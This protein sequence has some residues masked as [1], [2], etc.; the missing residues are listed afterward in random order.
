M[1]LLMK[2]LFG[3]WTN[4]RYIMHKIKAIYSLSFLY[5][6]LF[7]AY[8]ILCK[9]PINISILY[10]IIKHSSRSLPLIAILFYLVKLAFNEK[11]DIFLSNVLE[12]ILPL[13]FI[14]YFLPYF[15]EYIIDPSKFTKGI[16][17][18]FPTENSG[19]VYQAP[20]ISGTRIGGMMSSQE[21]FKGIKLNILTDPNVNK[22]LKNIGSGAS[23]IIQVRIT[24]GKPQIDTLNPHLYLKKAKT[25]NYLRLDNYIVTKIIPTWLFDLKISGEM[26][27]TI[28]W[29]TLAIY[30]NI[31]NIQSHSLVNKISVYDLFLNDEGWNIF[32]LIRK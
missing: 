1:V 11:L 14:V 7:I 9:S 4:R 17:N 25:D 15:N 3:K 8:I 16:S 29:N 18:G 24:N 26:E 27:I 31:E 22:N 13:L 23:T 21:G 2:F 28:R 12:T 6:I 30:F 32:E 5:L 20:K 10:Y 19:E